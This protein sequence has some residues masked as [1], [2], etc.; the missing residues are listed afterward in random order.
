MDT[1]ENLLDKS[2]FK[3]VVDLMPDEIKDE[4]INCSD[5][6]G[7]RRKKNSKKMRGG[8]DSNFRKRVIFGI[9]LFMGIV[10]S[11]IILNADTTTLVRGFELLYSGQCNSISELALDYFGIG[12]PICT[13]HHRMIVVVGAALQGRTEAIMQ[14]VGMVASGIAAPVVVYRAIDNLASLIEGRVAGL[15]GET[16]YAIENINT[17]MQSERAMIQVA[18]DDLNASATAQE[19]INQIRSNPSLVEALR[20]VINS[21]VHPEMKLDEEEIEEVYASSQPNT[22]QSQ[23]SQDYGGSRKRRYLKSKKRQN[24]KNKKTTKKNKN[25]RRIRRN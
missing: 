10:V 24:K 19:I 21:N 16:G 17:P 7:G 5:T 8:L 13:N 20:T 14:I 9:Y 12:N 22:Q 11:Y 2:V 15:I 3:F 4:F 1:C 25:S 23:Q 18:R 6:K